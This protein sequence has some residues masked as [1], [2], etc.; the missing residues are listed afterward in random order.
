MGSVLC[1]IITQCL[2]PDFLFEQSNGKVQLLWTLWY[3]AI[4]KQENET[5][6][7]IKSTLLSTLLTDNHP[8]PEQSNAWKLRPVSLVFD[9]L[10]HAERFF[11]KMLIRGPQKYWEVFCKNR[12]VLQKYW[13][14]L[15]KYWK[16]CWVEFHTLLQN[17]QL[18]WEN[19]VT[20]C[21]SCYSF[22]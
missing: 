9:Y 17:E 20:L 16:D 3:Q 21:V 11:A 1:M 13:G 10:G 8:F 14:V 12:G 7:Y 19:L 2:I 6:C 15:Q 18:P 4:V 22:L 5:K